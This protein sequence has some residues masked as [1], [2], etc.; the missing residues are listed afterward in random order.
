MPNSGKLAKWSQTKIRFNCDAV[1]RVISIGNLR[2]RQCSWALLSEKPRP[3]PALRTG[4]FS[5]RRFFGPDEREAIE[6]LLTR[7]AGGRKAMSNRWRKSGCRA[8][9]SDKAKAPRRRAGPWQI[10]RTAE[11]GDPAT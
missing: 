6:R 5:C 7:R 10:D 1:E 11:V 3:M 9:T 4:P 2:E 8:T